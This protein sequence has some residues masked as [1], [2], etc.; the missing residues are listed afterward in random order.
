LFWAL[1][2]GVGLGANLTPVAAA[3]NVVV[4]R[5]SEKLHGPLGLREWLRSGTA[6]TITTLVVASAGLALAMA[7]GV[8]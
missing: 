3:S 1:A 2:L 4:V 8:I 6:A 7:W 5:M